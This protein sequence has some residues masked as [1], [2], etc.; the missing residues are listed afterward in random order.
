MESEWQQVSSRHQNSFLYSGRSQQCCSLDGLG[1]SSDF[2]PFHPLTKYLGIVPNAPI[3]IGI[4]LTSMYHSSL[5]R[6]KYLFLFSFSLIFT[7]C[8]TGTAK[9]I[10]RQVLFSSSF[11]LSLTRSG[12]FGRGYFFYR[13]HQLQLVSP[14]FSCSIVFSFS[15]AKCRYLSLFSLSFYPVVSQ[16][17]KV[18]YSAGSIFCWISLGLVV[19]PWCFYLKI[20]KNFVYLIF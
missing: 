15:L 10:I 4:T 14:S 17:G 12:F 5:A 3:A 9:S 6:S 7:Q 19:W 2:Q 16:N 20:P 11:L 18:N 8:S 1:S 13:A